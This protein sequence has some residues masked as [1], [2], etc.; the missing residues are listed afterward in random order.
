MIKHETAMKRKAEPYER[1]SQG[2][3]KEREENMIVKKTIILG[4]Y[5]NRLFNVKWYNL[6]KI[7]IWARKYEY[8]SYEIYCSV[9]IP[10]RSLWKIFFSYLVRVLKLNQNKSN[11]VLMCWI[12]ISFTKDAVVNYYGTIYS[13]QM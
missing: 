13:V 10:E 6:H 8:S 2:E 9:F 4:F 1:K 11:W 3:G 12:I 5:R 7:S